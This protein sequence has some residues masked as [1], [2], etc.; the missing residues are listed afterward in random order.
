MQPISKAI[1]AHWQEAA[2]VAFLVGSVL[3]L[4]NQFEAVFGAEP[5]RVLPAI[6]TYCVPFS[7]FLIGKHSAQKAAEESC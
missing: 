4:I 2:K 3:L 5:L 1:K 6:L 7:V